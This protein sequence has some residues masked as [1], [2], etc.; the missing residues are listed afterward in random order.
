MA[1]FG[2]E[3]DISLFR[4]INRE[5]IGDVITQQ[6]ALYKFKL[7]ETNVNMYGEAAEEKFL[8]F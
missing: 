1:L 2:G 6:C 3:R 5:L 7:E 8:M 4:K